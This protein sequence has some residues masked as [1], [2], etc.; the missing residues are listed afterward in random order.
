MTDR[1]DAEAVAA[2]AADLVRLDSRSF[3]SNLAVADR[4]EAELAGFD[5]E[6]LDFT[7]PAGVPKRAL[8]AHRGG[9]GGLAL[10]GHMDTV[11]D[12]GWTEDPW[13]G[14]VDAEGI[15]HGL[16]SAD[17][18]GPLAACIVAVRGLPA[19]VPAT[20]LITTDEETTKAGAITIA[21]RSELARR[22]GLRGIIVAE[23]TEL[24]PIRGHRGNVGFDVV[25]TG[26]QAHSSTGKGVNAN[27]ALIPF[28]AEMRALS[29]RLREDTAFHDDAY[30]PPYPDFNLILDNHGAALN[31]TVPRATARIKFR[32]SCGLDPAPVIKAVEEAATRAGLALTVTQD[33]TP[34]ELPADHPLVA[35]AVAVTGKAARTVPFGTDASHL[36]ALAPCV[37]LGPGDIG[38][39]HTP[40]EHV[41]LSALAAAVPLYRQLMRR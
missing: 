4:L 14:R 41:A 40:R 27:W 3:V 31:V 34:P 35:E 36:N 5:V 16:G 10:S 6:R 11:P 13:S 24:S 37:I 23:P 26:V 15:L 9:T 21:E 20:L 7:D 33:G 32:Y 28:L 22:A 19:D 17:M 2:L 30:D 12:T 38:V 8:V 18:K 29:Q 39:A 25:A 1:T